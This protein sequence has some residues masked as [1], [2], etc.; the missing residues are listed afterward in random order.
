[1]K[2]DIREKILFILLCGWVVTLPIMQIPVLPY[3]KQKVQYSEAFAILIFCILAYSLVTKKIKYRFQGYEKYLLFVFISFT[4]STVLSIDSFTSIIELIGYSYLWL[5]FLAFPLIL[6]ND[7]YINKAINLYI[8][9]C[10]LLSLGSILSIYLHKI[11]FFQKGVLELDY[12]ISLISDQR[13][14]VMRSTA[15]TRH[16]TMVVSILFVGAIFICMKFNEKLTISKRNIKFFAILIL[17]FISFY[18]CKSRAIAGVVLSILIILFSFEKDRFTNFLKFIYTPFATC[19]L[20]FT[21]TISFIWVFPIQKIE[22]GGMYSFKVNTTPTAYFIQHMAGRDIGLEYPFF[23]SGPGTFYNLVVNYVD[24]DY[25]YA[26]YAHQNFAGYRQPIDPHS[27]FWGLFSETGVLGLGSFILFLLVIN[28]Y[29]YSNWTE[30]SDSA[31]WKLK[32]LSALLAGYIF[33]G[34][35]LEF[36][37]HRWFWF[38]L[39][40]GCSI[41]KIEKQKN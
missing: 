9:I 39:G 2:T 1:M 8:F 34:I 18:F 19:F 27:F 11:P 16:P 35:T 24:W 20:I 23:G 28:R 22:K 6:K 29:F 12:L 40:I 3:L 26:S 38:A 32:C 13:I 25:A 30:I 41:L 31:K 37:T 7:N 10:I 33:N 36:H 5:M 17:F 14:T 15:T 21:L 4:I